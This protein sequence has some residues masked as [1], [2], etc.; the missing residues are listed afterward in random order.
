MKLFLRGDYTV[1]VKT[2]MEEGREIV[3]D[4][5]SYNWP[6]GT[7]TSEAEIESEG[8]ILH[9]IEDCQEEMDKWTAWQAK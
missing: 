6:D 4:I 9:S 2:E 5:V 7:P 1:T 3:T 8:L